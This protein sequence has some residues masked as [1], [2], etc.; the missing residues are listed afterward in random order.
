MKKILSVLFVFAMLLTGTASIFSEENAPS[1]EFKVYKE[2][3]VEITP[4]ARTCICGG[5]FS[6]NRTIEQTTSGTYEV[7]C[8]H[9]EFGTDIVQDYKSYQIYRCGNW[10]LEIQMNQRTYRKLVKCGGYEL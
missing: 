1:T 10:G 4:Y 7:N 3:D 5:V 9:H 2:L 8:T 6:Y